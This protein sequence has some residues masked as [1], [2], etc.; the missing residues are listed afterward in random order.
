MPIGIRSGAVP[1]AACRATKSTILIAVLC[2]GVLVGNA[3]AQLVRVGS[4]RLVDVGDT[5]IRR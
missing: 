4:P 3:S 2:A 5:I 1:L